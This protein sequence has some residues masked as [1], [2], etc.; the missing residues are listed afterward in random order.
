MFLSPLAGSKVKGQWTGAIDKTCANPSGFA[1][2][3]QDWCA[4]MQFHT[5]GPYGV[6]SYS[7]VPLDNSGAKVPVY[8]A[9]G[10]DDRIIWCVD[11]LGP[12][13]PRNCLT[14]QFYGS[15]KAEYCPRQSSL[16]VD[17]FAGVGHLQVPAAAATNPKTGSYAGSPL[18]QFVSGAIAG[19]LG[20]TCTVNNRRNPL[21]Q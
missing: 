11:A 9:Q 13:S 14:A 18:E 5:P 12:V 16:E 7:K 17:Y 20:S 6:N 3:V 8:L 15:M 1:Q 21:P 19:T 2:A 10:R 4:W